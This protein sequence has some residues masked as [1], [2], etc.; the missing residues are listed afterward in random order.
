MR[1]AFIAA[2]LMW[3]AQAALDAEADEPCAKAGNADHRLRHLLMWG[4]SILLALGAA[5]MVIAV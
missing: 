1:F 2:Q 4:A 5:A 3:Q